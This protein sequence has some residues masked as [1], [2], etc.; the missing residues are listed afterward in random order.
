LKDRITSED[1]DA[2]SE[3]SIYGQ[4]IT[5][6]WKPI[7]YL[8]ENY[9]YKGPYCSSRINIPYKT[10][11]RYN[12]FRLYGDEAILQQEIV[13]DEKDSPYLRSPNLGS[14]PPETVMEEVKKG[15]TGRIV[16]R[17]SMR[18]FQGT[19]LIDRNELDWFRALYHFMIRFILGVGDSGFWN[20][21]N[22]YGIDYEENR[23]F[24]KSIE[25]VQQALFCK[26][27]SNKYR[28]TVSIMLKRYHSDLKDKL[29]K[30]VSTNASGN[31]LE[32]LELLKKLLETEVYD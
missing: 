15:L 16:I 18:V 1:L 20:Y 14:W 17:N 19:E 27:L 11:E 3:G 21:I 5:S 6:S 29:D 23:N 25:T 22:N 4:K 10:V 28:N 32:R 26:P 30:F 2:D 12:K 31:E 8:T 24:K 9:V 13:L 7:T